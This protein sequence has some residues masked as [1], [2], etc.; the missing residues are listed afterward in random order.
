MK[1]I[2]VNS[3]DEFQKTVEPQIYRKWMY[4]GQS[5][6]S[7]K[8]ESSLF[9][10]LKKNQDIRNYYSASLS[11]PSTKLNREIY[12]SE[13]I[14]HFMKSAHLYLSSVPDRENKFD[15]LSLMQHYGT[16]T[17]MLDFT[18]SPYVALAFALSGIEKE[19]AVYCVKFGDIMQIDKAYY[20]DIEKK[21]KT[22]MDKQKELAKTLLLPFEPGFI[23][24]RLQAQQGAFLIPNTL[25]YSHDE[26]LEHYS[27]EEF[28][29]KLI[30]NIED[31]HKMFMKLFQMNISYT[32][33][34]PGLEGFCKSFES[35]GIIPIKMLRPIN[36]P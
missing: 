1:E 25:T 28:V 14:S 6:S 4:R 29:M 3:W 20:D 31:T 19:A 33:L 11:K 8:L 32:N 17:R 15:W 2:T 10:I 13:I 27:N 5:N 35:I 23:N 21:Y 34:F 24:A 18:F 26:I 12:E 9:R 7:W 22:I 36:E 30:I 16:P